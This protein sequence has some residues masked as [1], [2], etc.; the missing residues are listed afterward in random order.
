M[1][2]GSRAVRVFYVQENKAQEA[3]NPALGTLED[4][5]CRT[6]TLHASHGV[7][8]S[9]SLPTPT[10]LRAQ[11]SRS[12]FKQECIVWLFQAIYGAYLR[13]K[14]G[15]SIM[16]AEVIISTPKDCHGS[17]RQKCVGQTLEFSKKTL[18]FL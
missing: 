18:T 9:G 5:L 15:S 2:G 13:G 16:G 8:V 17:L 6:S 3:S 11:R 12:S 7:K 1:G 14:H 4:P 10:R